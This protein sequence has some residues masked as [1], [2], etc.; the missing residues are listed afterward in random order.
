MSKAILDDLHHS[1]Q[2]E[3]REIANEAEK[4]IKIAQFLQS[5]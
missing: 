4:T 5:D 2:I 1:D 3:H